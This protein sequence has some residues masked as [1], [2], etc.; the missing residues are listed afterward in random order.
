MAKATTEFVKTSEVIFLVK[1]RF[2]L[3]HAIRG[4]GPAADLLIEEG[5]AGP[6]GDREAIYQALKDTGFVQTYDEDGDFLGQVEAIPIT[7]KVLK[8]AKAKKK[9]AKE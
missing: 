8:P 2:G 7:R 9:G 5:L 3:R 4:A 1:N 6:L